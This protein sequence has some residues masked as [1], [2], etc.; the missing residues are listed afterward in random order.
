M[1]FSGPDRSRVRIVKQIVDKAVAEAVRGL[2]FVTQTY[3]V[4]YS[5]YDGTVNY[6]VVL[7]TKGK[8][9]EVLNTN[10]VGDWR[11]GEMAKGVDGKTYKVVG[12]TSRG[13]VKIE[14]ALGKTYRCKTMFL[15]GRI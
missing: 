8:E 12:F 7:I 2:G 5:S 6:K 9:A 3:N 10:A 4:K 1:E 15:A 13:S 11:V 14:S